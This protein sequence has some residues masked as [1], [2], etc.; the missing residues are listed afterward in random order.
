MTDE[1]IIG[2]DL[3]A[4]AGG[5]SLGAR[6]AG[7]DV[8]LAVEKNPHAAA[9]YAHNHPETKVVVDDVANVS[10]IGVEKRG[11]I[12]VLFGGPPCQGFSTSNQRTRG[13]ANRAN[14]LF[15]EFLRIVSAWRPDWVVF[16]N[17]RGIVE[18]EGGLFRDRILG[19]LERL[20][21]DTV[22]GVL[23]AANF[24]VPQLRS[25]FFVLGTLRDVQIELPKPSVRRAV[26]V[27]Q[28]IG[29]L[30]EL[31]NGA[32]VDYLPYP[33]GRPSIYAKMM[34][35]RRSG[36]R[37]HLV[38]D[39]APQVVK[40]YCHIP[41]GGN[42]ESIPAR[43]MKNYADRTR[44]HTG[45]YR[46]LRQDEPSCVIGNF[47]KNML[48]HPTQHRGL[49]VREAARLQSFPDWYEFLGSIGFQ[50]QQVG[51]AVP[52]LLAKEVFAQIVRTYGREAGKAAST[53]NA[54]R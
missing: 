32:N 23:C 42:W 11:R 16:E 52:P 31:P 24:G 20:G 47:R 3:F 26:N 10:D 1:S 53:W 40:R 29:D 54:R 50:Q 43:L 22:N 17:V 7:I 51:D 27:Q 35:G 33:T 46:R 8:R 30:P 36:C 39:N 21:Y 41:P 25:R 9:T 18:T 12:S 19:E 38:T 34:R 2:I 14:W 13:S 48:V 15:T 44:C 28:A 45:I 4:G 49:S 6:M 5:M 37:N